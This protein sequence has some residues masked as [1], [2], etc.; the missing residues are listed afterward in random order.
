M[1]GAS[2]L[3]ECEAAV[4]GAGPYGL[5]VAAH[6]RA[7]K[8]ATRIFGAPMS[9]WRDHMP[10]GMMLRSPWRATHIADPDGDLSLDVYAAARSIPRTAHAAL[11]DF[12]AYGEWFVSRVA[13]DVDTRKV[14]L[15]EPGD[16]GY[17]LRLEDGAAVKARRVIMATGL[18]RQQFVPAPFAGLP[19]GRVSH[20]CEHTD[21]T[22]FRAQKVAVIGRGQSAAESAAL[23]S[24]AGAEVELISRGPFH[25]LGRP[26]SGG[27]VEDGLTRRLQ[28]LLAAPSAVGPFPLSWLVEFPGLAHR[29]PAAGRAWFNG[30]ALRPAAMAW[31]KAR[32][33]EVRLNP[34]RRIVGATATASRVVLE[35]DNGEAH[36]DHVV[37]ATGYRID[38]AKLGILDRP[39]LQ[40][41]NAID[42]IPILGS[43]LES[44]MPGLHFVGAAAVAS[45]GPL[46]R[47][48]AGCGFAARAV[49]RA[50]LMD[51]SWPM[52]RTT[53]GHRDQVLAGVVRS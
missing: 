47:F 18:A 26:S 23:L 19:P 33:G 12:I 48:I 51:R 5:A 27:G 11:E 35:L 1:G 13:Q 24:E 38:I 2:L 14:T 39:V 16:D 37:L 45:F 43:G 10:K 21:F 53:V 41:V 42:G 17:R 49:T 36:F 44:S 25:W 22:R 50:A 6:L 28:D 8:I 32:C 4:I 30:R 7:A 40:Q 52:A 3:D 31:L 29:L 34:D 20:T 15:V 46:M 9:F